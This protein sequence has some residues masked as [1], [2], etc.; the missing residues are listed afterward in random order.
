[1]LAE[2][3]K[4]VQPGAASEKSVLRLLEAQR[5]CAVF[6]SHLLCDDYTAGN[7]DPAAINGIHRMVH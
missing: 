2:A 6:S 7:C 5:V 1:M 3:D 4:V